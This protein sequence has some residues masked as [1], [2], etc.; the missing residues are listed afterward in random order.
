MGYTV[1]PDRSAGYALDDVDWDV[2]IK[3]NFNGGTWVKLG[4]AL[5]TGASGTVT[6]SSIN[7]TFRD[8]L[9]VFSGRSTANTTV[10]IGRIRFNG[11]NG[12][13]YDTQWLYG[14]GASVIATQNFAATGIVT[15]DFPGALSPA[16]CFGHGMFV[17]PHY[18]N[19]TRNKLIRMWKTHKFSTVT[20]M[21]TLAAGGHWR[22]NSAITSLSFVLQTL[23]WDGGSIFSLYATP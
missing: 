19:T 2:S 14:D 7:G 20:D 4:E 23:N 3:D 21:I 11:D 10:D 8:L 16:N 18:A 6:F 15:G 9:V 22:S 1:V 5:G 13:N 12:A 17:V